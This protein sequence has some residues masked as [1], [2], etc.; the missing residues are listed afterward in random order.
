MPQVRYLTISDHHRVVVSQVTVTNTQTQFDD[1]VTTV[2]CLQG[3]AVGTFGVEP[4][5]DGGV[6]AV[7]IEAIFRTLADGVLVLREV[8]LF[9]IYRQVVVVIVE[10]VRQ[11]FGRIRQVDF[12]RIYVRRLELDLVVI[13]KRVGIF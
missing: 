10:V 1:T 7:D 8:L 9:V 2:Q 12:C 13:C 11:M 6:V 5:L 3:I 4:T